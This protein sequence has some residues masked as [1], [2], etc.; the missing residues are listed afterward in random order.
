MMVVSRSTQFDGLCERI[1]FCFIQFLYLYVHIAR[2]SCCKID[3]GQLHMIFI[4]PDVDETFFST[5]IFLEKRN[6]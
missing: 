3:F 2:S 5:A 6:A 4:D 1:H